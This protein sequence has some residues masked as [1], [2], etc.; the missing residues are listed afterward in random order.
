MHWKRWGDGER[1]ILFLPTWSII[2]SRSWKAQVPWF[3]RRYRVLTFDPRG[4]GLS[5]RPVDPAAYA[6]AEY[7]ADALAVLDATGTDRAAIVGHS[8]GAHRGLLL[9]ADHPERVTAAIFI[10]P[11]LPLDEAGRRRR[12]S[13]RTSATTRA[14]RG[15]TPTP[16]A[17]TT[18]ASSSSSPPRSTRSR[19]RRS[20]S[21][22]SSTGRATSARMG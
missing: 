3:S 13:R 19:T 12:R 6:E 20:R 15:T 16:G 7:A 22:T 2:H 18:V 9:A 8:R 4:N 14:G 11:A 21:R 5:D 17:A 1:T 10:G